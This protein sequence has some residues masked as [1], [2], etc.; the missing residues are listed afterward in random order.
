[1]T[2][3]GVMLVI[4]AVAAVAVVYYAGQIVWIHTHRDD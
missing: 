2:V 4:G 1:M 3:F